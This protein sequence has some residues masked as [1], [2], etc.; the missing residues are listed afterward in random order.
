MLFCFFI[1][2]HKIRVSVLY[3]VPCYCPFGGQSVWYSWPSN[4]WNSGYW[5]DLCHYLWFPLPQCLPHLSEVECCV[6]YPVS[7][8]WARQLPWGDGVFLT[9]CACGSLLLGQLQHPP[10]IT[11]ETFVFVPRERKAVFSFLTVA[12]KRP[13]TS[14][15]IL[16]WEK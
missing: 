2:F 16:P 15:V 8:F 12:V 11:I 14:M 9:Y 6:V 13:L 7:T 4:E 1:F 10:L 3:I 5:L